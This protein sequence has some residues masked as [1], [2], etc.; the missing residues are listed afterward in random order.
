MPEWKDLTE[1][2]SKAARDAAY[3]I[4]GLGVLGV[5]RAQVRRR[6]LTRRLADP[7]SEFETRLSGARGEITKRVIEVDTAVEQV[8]EKLEATLE[9]LEGRLPSQARQFVAQARSQARE[10]RLQLRTLL[11]SVAA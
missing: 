4:V 6:E 10:A 8:I 5:Q 9:P 1:E 11:H 3:V 2:I 7:R